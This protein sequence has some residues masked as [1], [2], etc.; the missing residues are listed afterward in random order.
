MA[1]ITAVARLLPMTRSAPLLGDSVRSPLGVS[2][3]SLQQTVQTMRS[4]WPKVIATIEAVIT[5][6]DAEAELASRDA[7]NQLT[8][9]LPETVLCFILCMII[10]VWAN[11]LKGIARSAFQSAILR[12]LH[13]LDEDV[14][15]LLAYFNSPFGKTC[16]DAAV[17]LHAATSDITNTP[18]RRRLDPA[19]SGARANEHWRDLYQILLH[20]QTRTNARKTIETCK[21]HTATA[22]FAAQGANETVNEFFIRIRDAHELVRLEF[23][24]S[25]F[26]HLAPELDECYQLV[27][28]KMKA[29]L[30]GPFRKR[31]NKKQLSYEQMP[32]KDAYDLAIEVENEAPT[33]NSEADAIID[34][35]LAD[36][37]PDGGKGGRGGGRRNGTNREEK[38]TRRVAGAVIGRAL[39]G[40][41][42]GDEVNPPYWGKPNTTPAFLAADKLPKEEYDPFDNAVCRERTGHDIP[43]FNQ[44]CAVRRSEKERK[45]QGRDSSIKRRCA[46]CF[47]VGHSEDSCF[48]AR[49]DTD[50]WKVGHQGGKTARAERAAQQGQPRRGR[51]GAEPKEETPQALRQPAPPSRSSLS[52]AAQLEHLVEDPEL[53]PVASLPQYDENDEELPP[54][55][56]SVS[57]SALA[58]PALPHGKT[59]SHLTGEVVDEDWDDGSYDWVEDPDNIYD[60]CR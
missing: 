37:A 33:P 29:P 30:L 15:A 51:R 18:G 25:D 11:K 7:I 5:R 13:T 17:G 44:V 20:K 50:P 39:E 21:R 55:L 16:P 22:N 43:Q 57:F 26:P 46:N 56:R 3:G 24:T 54:P 28:H 10:F 53:A 1:A 2:Q 31:C 60:R 14:P 48:M 36:T 27:L 8:D 34:A 12:Y 38:P 41:S 59:Y 23:A 47:G 35:R 58:S 32:I 49:F 9:L 19:R 52:F 40:L 6:S 45:A 4:K 42:I